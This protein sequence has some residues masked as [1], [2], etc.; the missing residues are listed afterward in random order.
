ML[1]QYLSS[2]EG[3]WIY[4]VISLLIF[5]SL[6]IVIVARLYRTDKNLLNK[7]ANLPLENENNEKPNSGI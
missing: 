1:S 2:M 5:I 3:L 4:P 7:L 6:F